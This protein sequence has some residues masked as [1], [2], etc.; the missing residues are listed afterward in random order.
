[1]CFA[2]LSLLYAC[3]CW[4]HAAAEQIESDGMR[5]FGNSASKILSVQQ[6]V[7]CDVDKETAQLGCK[8]GEEKPNSRHTYDIPTC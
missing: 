4:A 7:S 1:M 8:G 6:F 3:S 2:Q 5:L